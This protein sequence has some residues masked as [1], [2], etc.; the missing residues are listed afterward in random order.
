MHRL[1]S[2]PD[3][4]F[5]KH[6][7]SNNPHCRQGVNPQTC[8]TKITKARRRKSTP[9]QPID[10]D[11]LAEADRKD[12]CP[13]QCFSPAQAMLSGFRQPELQLEGSKLK[14]VPVSQLSVFDELTIET[15]EGF[16]RGLE[17]E[18]LHRIKVDREM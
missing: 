10:Q 15:D 8:K 17:Q 13:S 6:S 14:H 16:G 1:E 4:F 18:S 5:R 9:Q 7:F 2:V 11:D 12:S 3:I